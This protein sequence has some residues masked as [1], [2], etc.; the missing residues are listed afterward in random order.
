MLQLPQL[1]AP[2]TLS[3][4]PDDGFLA[5]LRTRRIWHRAGHCVV[6]ADA[7]AAPEIVQVIRDLGVPLAITFNL[8]RLMVLPHGVSKASGLEEA[9]WPC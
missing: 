3:Q 1:E 6:E 4:A 8:G 2:V 5:E 7:A 9:L